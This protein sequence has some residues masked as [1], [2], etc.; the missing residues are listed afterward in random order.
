MRLGWTYLQGRWLTLLSL[1]AALGF[2]ALSGAVI[3]DLR[4][5]TWARAEE[6]ARNLNRAVGQDIER[7]FKIFDLSLQAVVAGLRHPG[8]AKLDPELRNLILFDKAATA[9]HLGSFI[10]LDATGKIVMDAASVEPR[11]DNLAD[12][13]YFQVHRDRPDVGLYVSLPFFGR[14]TNQWLVGISRRLS[15]P[16]GSFAGVVLG[17]LKLDHFRHL[18]GEL[19]LGPGG[20]I[21]LLR[22]DGIALM[23]VPDALEIIGRDFSGGTAFRAISRAQEGQYRKVSGLDGVD[24]LFMFSR[25]GDLPLI[26][27]VG[28]AVK[29]IEAGWRWRAAIIGGTTLI[30]ASALLIGTL[31]LHRE[32]AARRA[33][34]AELARLV[35]L[36]GLTGLANRRAFDEALGRE[37]SRCALAGTLVSLLLIDVDRFKAL[38]DHYGHQTGDKCLRT[39]AATIGTAV[40]HSSDLVARYGGEE[41]AVLLPDTDA[42]AAEEVA[43]RLRAEIEK[44]C[45]SHK[46]YGVSGAVVTVSIGV[47]TARPAQSV[48]QG[49]EALVEAADHALYEAKRGGRNRVMQAA[50]PALRRFAAT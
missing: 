40:R 48:L 31:L 12:R 25:I 18:F 42:A 13:D 22:A 8:V 34:E 43:E 23:R 50:P 37:W 33:K 16:D 24:R 26:L 29:D 3:L 36:D 32:V 44:L 14:L 46:G 15:H 7:T 10:V 38:N 27:N 30:L 6:A 5:D 20:R 4:R 1:L 21:T 49:P 2:C 11:R 39:I 47:A 28:L 19:S 17:T 45:I 41:F 35:R 9:Q